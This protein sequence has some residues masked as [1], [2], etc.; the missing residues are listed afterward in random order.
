M[1]MK[2]NVDDGTSD[3]MPKA[4]PFIVLCNESVAFNPIDVRQRIDSWS[5]SKPSYT[6]PTWKFISEIESML[7]AMNRK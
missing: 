6:T 7:L 1:R 4:S 2:H 5:L 3:Q